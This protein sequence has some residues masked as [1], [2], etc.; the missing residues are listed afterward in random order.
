MPQSTPS[1]DLAEAYAY[2]DEIARRDKPHL[3][4]A[5]QHFEHRATREA[6][7]AAYASMRVID[8]FVDDIPGR[9]TLGQESRER[10]AAYV[11]GWLNRVREAKAGCADEAPVWRALCHTFDRFG[12]PIEPW[13]DLAKAMMTDLAVSMFRDWDHLRRYMKGASVAPAVIFM[14]L[15]LAK[16]HSDGVTFSC[17]WPYERVAAATEDLAIF[18]YWVHILR[19]AAVDL[20]TGKTGLVYFP[21][22][23]LKAF[24]LSAN[25]LHEMRKVRR[26]TDA[27]V[28]LAKLE[29]GRARDHLER[30]RAYFPELLASTMP[31]HG[32]ALT[33]L[34]GTYE[35]ILQSLA[36]IDYD[37]FSHPLL[38]TD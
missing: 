30:G 25:D 24:H 31:S 22:A 8:D 1:V 35:S 17:P 23:D 32:R 9:A 18:C 16:P 15:V 36:K 33:L 38:I 14:H 4:T 6:F 5:A 12:L 26:A 20:T 2:C 29:A 3:Y 7:A 13:Q 21:H 10:A 19:D 11:D 27:Y 34:I 37:V 28:Q